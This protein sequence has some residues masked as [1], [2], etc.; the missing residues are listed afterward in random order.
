[1]LLSVQNMVN[2]VS[3]SF[4]FMSSLLNSSNVRHISQHTILSFLGSQEKA[5]DSLPKSSQVANRSNGPPYVQPMM[6]E[7]DDGISYKG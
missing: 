6:M 2:Q 1:M 7:S 3:C 5:I 4:C